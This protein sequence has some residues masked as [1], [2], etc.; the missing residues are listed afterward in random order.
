MVPKAEFQSYLTELLVPHLLDQGFEG[1]KWSW[2]RLQGEVINCVIV[3]FERKMQACCVNLG[4]H[5]TFLPVAGTM[6]PP[7]LDTVSAFDCEIT[8]R[9]APPPKASC[10]WSYESGKS[11]A[12]SLVECFRSNGDQF[13]ERFAQFPS[14]F[15]GPSESD[16]LSELHSIVPFMTDTRLLLLLA[17]VNR[18]LK[19]LSLAESYCERALATTPPHARSVIGTL[20]ALQKELKA[21]MDRARQ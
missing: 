15:D 13:F 11:G 19:N 7:D 12:V 14:P 6:S 17:R 10:W 2:R 8:N 5:F 1:R 16:I 21:E 18:Y 3:Q 20:E 4:V 9:L